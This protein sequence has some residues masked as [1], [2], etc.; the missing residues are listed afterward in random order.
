METIARIAPDKS[1]NG[2]DPAN[3]IRMNIEKSS[4]FDF[5]DSIMSCRDGLCWSQANDVAVSLPTVDARQ[6]NS[7][8]MRS[9]HRIVYSCSPSSSRDI[10]DR[11]DYYASRW[12]GYLPLSP[13]PSNDLLSPKKAYLNRRRI[14]R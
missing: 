4:L 14:V 7:T 5:F 6:D 9:F 13:M 8:S 12:Q 1:S 10:M 3:S 2:V 11:Q